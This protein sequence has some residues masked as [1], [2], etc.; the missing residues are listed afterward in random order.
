MLFQSVHF[1]SILYVIVRFFFNKY[2]MTFPAFSIMKGDKFD[3]FNG[4]KVWNQQVR[5]NFSLCI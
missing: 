1:R 3:D 2:I 5:L 4:S